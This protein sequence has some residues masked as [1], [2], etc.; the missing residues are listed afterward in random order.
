MRGVTLQEL[1]RQYR[2]MYW[3]IEAY[4][5]ARAVWTR[6]QLIAGSWSTGA[7]WR[8]MES[9]AETRPFTLPR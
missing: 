1:Y 5:H 3:P 2:A 6:G 4:V 7:M 9:A 8:L